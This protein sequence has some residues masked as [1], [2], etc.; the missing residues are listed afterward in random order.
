MHMRSTHDQHRNPRIISLSINGKEM[1]VFDYHPGKIPE[2]NKNPFPIQNQYHPRKLKK[3]VGN[4]ELFL[5]HVH[6]DLKFRG[7]IF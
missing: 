3:G 6:S 5:T 7:S 2:K 1:F 4:E